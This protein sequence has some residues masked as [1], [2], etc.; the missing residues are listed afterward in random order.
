M[1]KMEILVET[2]TKNITYITSSMSREEY[3]E[4][5]PAMSI[6]R[7]NE[8]IIPRVN[9]LGKKVRTSINPKK[10]ISIDIIEIEE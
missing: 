4:L 8:I 7:I 1:Y 9:K 6:R 3:E 2:Q 5:A 10:I